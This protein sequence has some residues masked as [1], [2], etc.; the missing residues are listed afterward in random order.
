MHSIR[1][2]PSGLTLGAIWNKSEDAN[3][4]ERKNK[5]KGFVKKKQKTTAGLTLGIRSLMWDKK[6]ESHLP[7]TGCL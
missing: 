4:K 3:N 1:E 5:V 7:P 2:T 6:C